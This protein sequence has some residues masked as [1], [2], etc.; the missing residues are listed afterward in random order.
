MNADET[1][2]NA[3]LDGALALL[4]GGSL[5]FLEGPTVRVTFTLASPACAAASGAEA[6]LDVSGPL[7]G[8]AAS[9]ATVALDGYEFRTSLGVARATGGVGAIGSGEDIEIN[10]PDVLINDVIQVSGY[11]FSMA[12]TP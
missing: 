11:T 4:N 1:M 12:A 9:S 8:T 6:E 3:A 2:R 7:Q 10:H 5:V